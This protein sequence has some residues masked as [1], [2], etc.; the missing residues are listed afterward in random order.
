[1]RRY[2]AYLRYVI[3]HKWFV[4]RAGLKLE[5]S[6]WRLLAHDLS[7]FLPSEFI[8]YAR[9]FYQKNGKLQY[10]E[11]NEFNLAWL[12]HQRRNCHHWQYW[13]LKCDDGSQFPMTMPMQYI[14]E[15]VADWIGAGRAIGN[16]AG[17]R[18]WYN[19]NRHKIVMTESTRRIAEWLLQKAE[20]VG[21]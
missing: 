2:I 8:P 19:R 20:D 17:A 3:R 4:L 7:K 15:M 10:N 6:L 18:V 12:M 9:C 14:Y 5:C 11:T 13:I 21:A 16:L 1:M